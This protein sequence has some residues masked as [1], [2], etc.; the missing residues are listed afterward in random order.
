MEKVRIPL[1][2][3]VIN[4]PELVK[5]GTAEAFATTPPFYTPIELYLYLDMETEA[6]TIEFGYDYSLS[7]KE[8]EAYNKHKVKF[9]F[10][11][12]SDRLLK[13]LIPRAEIISLWNSTSDKQEFIEKFE[14]MVLGKRLSAE[15]DYKPV[16]STFENYTNEIFSKVN[17]E[18]CLTI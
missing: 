5:F 18:Q 14:T 16:K 13:I 2:S 12:K 15:Q 9:I 7:E 8:R 1:D 11:K 6:L 17:A 4:K 10:G 3:S